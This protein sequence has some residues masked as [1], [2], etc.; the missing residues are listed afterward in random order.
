MS[1]RNNSAKSYPAIEVHVTR[2]NLSESVHSVDALV[3]DSKG[4]LV[5]GFGNYEKV[6]TY[7]RSTI[8]MIQALYFVES[9]AFASYGLSAAHLS[10]ACASHNGQK[11]HTELVLSWLDKI[12]LQESDL[13]CGPHIPYDERTAI[14]LIRKDQQPSRRHNN[15]SGKHSGILSALKKEKID[16]HHYGSYDHPLQKKFRQILTETS[17]QRMD[18]VPWGM[19]GCGIPTYA[20]TLT[21]MAKCLSFLNLNQPAHQDRHSALKIIR[22][23]VLAEPFYIGGTN[24]FC[25]DL[26]AASN[27]RFIMKAGAE[28][29]YA[30][31]FLEQGY[32]F[33]LK[34]RDGNSRASRVA[35]A[36]LLLAFQGLTE[37]EFVKLSRHT[38][39]L[40]KNYNGETIGKI[41]VPHPLIS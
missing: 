4:E 22:E 41:F 24:D 2:G 31:V 7:P 6:L 40:L 15:C 28:G 37:S 10:L 19:D 13:V 1:S 27:G 36:K 18:Q 35:V 38:E 25:S 33:A 17:G 26:L 23:S 12:Q 9:G 3:L 5:A 16:F 21:G 30:G 39:P 34:V 32:S 20:M 14:E 29:V 11:E 8:K